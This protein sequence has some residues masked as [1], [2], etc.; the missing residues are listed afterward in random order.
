MIDVGTLSEKYLEQLCVEN[1]NRKNVQY[2]ENPVHEKNACSFICIYNKDNLS[3]LN[4]FFFFNI[5]DGERS[6]I[7]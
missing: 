5:G 6:V 7:F 2:S 1:K 4:R 3:L